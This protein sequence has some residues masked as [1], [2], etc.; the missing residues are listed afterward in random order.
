M[1]EPRTVDRLLADSRWLTNLARRLV[2]EDQAAD[3]HQEV[4]LAALQH[5]GT[6][7]R[8][9]LA[10]VAHHLATTLRR[11][12][13][14]ERRRVDALPMP[15]PVPSPTELVATA[16]LQQRAVAA[17]LAL[18]EAQRDTVLM[19]FLEGLSVQA[20]ARA[21][22]VPEE[23]VR[24]RQRRAL[25][26]LR[27]QLAP[28]P[29]PR[30]RAF[31]VA[32]WSSVGW[33]SVM[34]IQHA[35]IAAALVLLWLSYA[36]WP[37]TNQQ[38]VEVSA[39]ASLEAGV[40]VE[41]AATPAN[42]AA[43]VQRELL[44]GAASENRG[45]TGSAELRFFWRGTELPAPSLQLW[46]R[47]VSDAPGRL[48]RVLADDRGVLRLPE[49][50]PGRYE[51]QCMGP[52]HAFAV[53]ASTETRL[54]IEV[55]PTINVEGIVVDAN[56]RRVAGA[57][58]FVQG[59]AD[60]DPVPRLVGT[61]DADGAFRARTDRGGWCWARSPG[62][63]A[64]AIEP[65]RSET[66]RLRLVLA[67]PGERVRGTVLTATGAPA[68]AA[69]VTIL[70]T[71]P[72]DL[73][74]VPVVV[75]TDHAGAFG[76]DELRP[77]PHLL[78]ASAPDHAPRCEPFVVLAG[79]E[80]E[81]MVQLDRGSILQGEVRSASGGDFVVM[82]RVE[83]SLPGAGEARLGSLAAIRETTQRL[84]WTHDGRYRL[85]GV[86]AG[87]LRL[88]VQAH[89]HIPV[90]RIVEVRAGESRSCDFVLTQGHALRGRLL[91]PMGKGIGGWNVWAWT[92]P[93]GPRALTNTDA[94]GSFVLGGLDADTCTVMARSRGDETRWLAT[95]AQ[96]VPLDGNELQLRTLAATDGGS[97]SGSLVL[98]TGANP[99]HYQVS[100]LPVD[101]ANEL[102]QTFRPK[103]DG[104]FVAGPVQPGRYVVEIQRAGAAVVE[105]GQLE[106]QACL[107]TDVGRVVVPVSGR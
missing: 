93:D 11:R 97:V 107:R 42:A 49:L 101:A 69:K 6:V 79:Q 41:S 92:T 35:A 17:V 16:E 86:P 48:H 89:D 88:Q 95:H 27:A 40:L 59:D 39:G 82:I 5:P 47:S 12:R 91:D 96:D 2:G 44:L 87:T 68:I 61:A 33:G 77:G 83:I 28:A 14:A 10:T 8:S 30:R 81:L 29:A 23:T 53:V 62:L 7:G 15:D 24:T 13:S 1:T 51:V 66:S 94:D 34:K 74:S 57:T 65:L 54:T 70:A 36:F 58:V 106:L 105:L 85:D 21:M 99:R 45:A 19:R 60:S 67:A 98:P 100:L 38:A 64:S 75:V 37:Q 71:E 4:A 102:R 63:A 3:L 18:P 32:L 76:C 78:V 9:W 104:S 103:K 72:R 55:A 80:Q 90:T 43:P 52:V 50:A 22:D 31:A 73:R 84:T 46:W 20:T 26:T 56:G 25:A